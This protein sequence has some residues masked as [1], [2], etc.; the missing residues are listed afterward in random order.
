MTFWI[1]TGDPEVRDVGD[2]V[3]LDMGD[4]LVALY[5][6]HTERLVISWNRVPVVVNY[7]DDLRVFVDDIVDLLEELRSDGFVQAELTTGAADFF[8]VWSFR[9][10]GENLVVD[11]R[12]DNIV[13][14]YEFLL[15]ERSRLIVRRTDFVAEWL[16]VIRRV[17]GDITAQSVSMEIDETFLR[18]KGLLADGGEAAGATGAT[19][20]V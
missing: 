2:E 12:W 15:N 17:V 10:E 14:N 7:C 6:D 5:P 13:G 9:P 1:Q 8:A 16:K 20:G 11:S 18:A 4:A 19:G 3:V